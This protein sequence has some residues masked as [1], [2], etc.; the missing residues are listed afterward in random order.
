MISS[1]QFESVIYYLKKHIRD[2][3]CWKS[4]EEFYDL[5]DVKKKRFEDYVPIHMSV[6]TFVTVVA[7]V[8]VCFH[9][10][11]RLAEYNHKKGEE[12][13]KKG[14]N[15]KKKEEKMHGKEFDEAVRRLG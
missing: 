12:E 14:Q 8:L 11:M 4:S 15:G 10:S 5:I 13:E 1:S 7:F 9:E 6:D 2:G 3:C